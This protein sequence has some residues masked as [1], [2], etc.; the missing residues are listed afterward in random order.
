MN[1]AEECR[2]YAEEAMKTDEQEREANTQEVLDDI[3]CQIKEIA[4]KGETSINLYDLQIKKKVSKE[5]LRE[6][7]KS[8]GFR[9]IRDFTHMKTEISWAKE[10]PRLSLWQEICL[11]LYRFIA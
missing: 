5:M 6:G 4:K 8:R 3:L 7:L 2:Q 11:F 1:F 9:V 10:E